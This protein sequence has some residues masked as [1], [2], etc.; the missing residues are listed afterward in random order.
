MV[1]V[2]SDQ[3][4]V[5]LAARRD[6]VEDVRMLFDAG[7][8]F[9]VASEAFRS[10]R[11]SDHL[12]IVRMMVDARVLNENTRVI[13]VAAEHGHTEIVRILISAGITAG[14][15]DALMVAASEGHKE[16]MDLLI[17]AGASSEGALQ[18]AAGAG[19]THIVLALLRAV[20][21]KQGLLV[22][23]VSGR[24][25]P[26][27]TDDRTVKEL[28]S[29]LLEAVLQSRFK[30]G[31]LLTNAGASVTIYDIAIAQLAQRTKMSRKARAVQIGNL[32]DSKFAR[33]EELA[34]G[35]KKRGKAPN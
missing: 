32:D 8:T 23:E 26:V 33:L 12:K 21:Q 13:D 18:R 2:V 4:L 25:A 9:V 28:N 3:I 20:A 16:I 31:R 6:S 15:N 7:A 10:A 24:A 29:A 11:G 27:F 17:D 34:S 30:V 14:M 19:H 5:Q 35:P 22:E 1:N